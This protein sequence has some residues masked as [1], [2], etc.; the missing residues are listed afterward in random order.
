MTSH[1]HI[2]K[3]IIKSL[4]NCGCG[5]FVSKNG[6]YAGATFG[7]LDPF[8]SFFFRIFFLRRHVFRV[9]FL[10]HHLFFLLLLL[11]SVFF[12]TFFALCFYV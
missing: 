10:R 9:L 12:Q 6:T 3:G 8:F 4:S 11:F 2:S 7:I 5:S 1:T